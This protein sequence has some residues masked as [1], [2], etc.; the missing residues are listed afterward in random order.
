[1]QLWKIENKILRKKNFPP[2]SAWGKH[3]GKTKKQPQTKNKIGLTRL[4]LTAL[5]NPRCINNPPC[6]LN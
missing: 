2:T 1:M 3:F 5:A 6:E 4:S